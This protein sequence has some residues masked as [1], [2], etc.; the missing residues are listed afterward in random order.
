MKQLR[1]NRGL[2]KWIIL[3]ILTL[4]I[5][6]LVMM[7]HIS[8]EINYVAQKD[9]KKT[10]NYLLLFFIIAPITFGLGYLIWW[11]RIC[12]RMGSELER[13]G[14]DYKFG[15]GTFWGWGILGAVILIG[16]LV[17]RYKFFKAMNLLNAAYN[18]PEEPEVT[19]PVY[20]NT[21]DDDDAMLNKL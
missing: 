10:M 14:I 11:H 21:S 13:R 18:N 9:G 1:T 7:Y 16:P 6:D 3:S 17:L 20:S 5:Y 8:D 19:A 12:S 4:G 2:V 15:A